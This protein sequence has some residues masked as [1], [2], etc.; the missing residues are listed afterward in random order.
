MF[1]EYFLHTL[2]QI[3]VIL[4]FGIVL[5]RIITFF[6]ID[7]LGHLISDNVGHNRV[8]VIVPARNEEKNITRCLKSLQA[9]DYDNFEVIVVDDCSTDDTLKIIQKFCLI[10][11]RFIAI[12]LSE[13][14]K[15]WAGKNFAC[16]QGSQKATGNIL[17]FTDADTDHS[18]ESISSSLAYMNK[19]HLDVLTLLPTLVCKDYWSKLI[20]PI[21]ISM[22]NLLYSPLFL[23]SKKLPIAYLIGGFILIN[24][25][26]YDAVGGHEAVKNSFVEDK[27]LG[28]LLKTAGYKLKFIRSGNIVKTFS[29]IGFTD[30]I[31]AMQRG[32]SSSFVDIHPFFGI[33]TIIIGFFALIL[34]YILVLQFTYFSLENILKIFLIVSFMQLSYFF[35]FLDVKH[36]KLYVFL[37]PFSCILLFTALIISV[38]KIQLNSPFTWRD[39]YYKKS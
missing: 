17:L 20:L 29:N 1:L 14:K 36:S 27:S 21:L 28:E 23:N 34:P 2:I 32:I 18:K 26:V 5:F 31:N 33:I 9:Q 38:V 8:S 19:F 35:E 6:Y 25:K 10:D 30:N 13:K 37:H 16:Y 4:W 22:I 3:L 39:R 7:E 15:N 12:R 11:D 24:R